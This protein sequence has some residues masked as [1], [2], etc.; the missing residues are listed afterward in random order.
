MR[1]S[2][3]V[4]LA[5]TLLS[6][7]FAD[8]SAH[9]QCAPEDKIYIDP[10]LVPKRGNMTPEQFKAIM[11]SHGSTPEMKARAQREYMQK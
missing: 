8:G 6:S 1:K 9:A 2:V 10:R 5:L 4:V 3:I 7:L 11:L